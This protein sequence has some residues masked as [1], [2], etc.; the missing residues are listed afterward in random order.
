MS[1]VATQ[2]K[3]STRPVASAKLRTSLAR[4]EKRLSVFVAG[5][6]LDPHWTESDLVGKTS[7]TILR[8]HVS[9]YVKLMECELILGEHSGVSEITSEVVPTSSSIAA[10]ELVLVRGAD[11]VI[12]IPDSP[13]SFCEL[14][15][16]SMIPTVCQKSMIFPNATFKE[17]SGYLQ[18]AL[19]PF[20]AHDYARI[21]WL[22][23]SD[24]AKAVGLVEDFL[25]RITDRVI[26]RGLK[27]DH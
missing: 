10:S 9:Q 13:G 16:W 12:L 25:G 3:Y 22:D 24:H 11:A 23:Y 15:S 1:T 6:F 14:G 18:N 20:L 26:I 7:G 19:L 4:I 27:N 17:N 21:E 2:F 8:Y 5:P